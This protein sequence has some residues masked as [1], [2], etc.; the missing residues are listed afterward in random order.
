MH[1]NT[2]L[3]FLNTIWKYLSYPQNSFKVTTLIRSC[4]H[5]LDKNMS[6][7]RAHVWWR[8][9]YWQR[10]MFSY[11]SLVVDFIIL[12]TTVCRYFNVSNRAPLL[13]KWL[14]SLTKFWKK[15]HL[16]TATFL[17]KIKKEEPQDKVLFREW[18]YGQNKNKNK[19]WRCLLVL[20][21]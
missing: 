5:Y 4:L 15:Y 14:G 21:G 1:S 12:S 8:A 3:S 17:F 6:R 13:L 19:I 18:L 16:Q 10:R 2:V 9:T 20:H 11:H 7:R